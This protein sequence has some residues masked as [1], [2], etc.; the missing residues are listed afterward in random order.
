VAVPAESRAALDCIWRTLCGHSQVHLAL[1]GFLVDLLAD[2]VAGGIA[3]CSRH[4]V[5]RQP[6]DVG[7]ACESSGLSHSQHRIG[8]GGEVQPLGGVAAFTEFCASLGCQSL[9]SSIGQQDSTLSTLIRR[10]KVRTSTGIFGLPILSG[11]ADVT[12]HL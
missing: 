5:I 11:Q 2:D 10:M 8:Q 6:P 3:G 1:A 4:P 7:I 12:P 9:D